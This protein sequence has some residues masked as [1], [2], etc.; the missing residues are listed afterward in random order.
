MLRLQKIRRLKLWHQRPNKVRLKADLGLRGPLLRT[1]IF[2]M[3]ARLPSSDQSHEAATQ[4]KHSLCQDFA[5]C[6]SVDWGVG[7]IF[8]E[9]GCEESVCPVFV[10]AEY[11]AGTHAIPRNEVVIP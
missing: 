6:L 8:H 4:S 3:C 7:C 10:R 5:P 1:I 2:A 11:E 9:D